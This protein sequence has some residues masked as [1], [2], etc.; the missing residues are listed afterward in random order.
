MDTVTIEA[1]YDQSF[2]CKYLACKGNEFQNLFADIMERCH[3]AD[4]IR[5]RPWGSHGDRKNNG[6][7]RSERTL[8]QIYAPNEMTEADALGKIDDD[9][10]GALPYWQDHFDIWV[11]AHNS[12]PGLG[13]GIT[14]RLLEL[15]GHDVSITVL[16]W[17]LSE[18]LQRVRRLA[19]ADLIALFGAV[20]TR[21]DFLNIQFPEL[22]T[23]LNFI[24]AQPAPSVPDI[25]PVPVTK[26]DF[27]GLTPG[28]RSFLSAGR[29]RARA[30]EDYFRRCSDVELGDRI[31]EAFRNEYRLCRDRGLGVE[32]LF[33]SL[34]TFAA[35]QPPLSIGRSAAV[36]VILAY[37]FDACDI[38]EEPREESPS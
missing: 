31:A 7:L 36:W 26:M 34:Q 3:P 14:A 10:F 2:R 13:P 15:D 18:I 28:I 6:Y 23:I 30:V 24:A 19:R 27:N 38:F 4:Y 11:F 5:T 29:L 9:F 35:G 12:A 33:A 16:S 32:D 25:H 21:H 1:W 22:Q 37:L 20:P 8:F 17:G